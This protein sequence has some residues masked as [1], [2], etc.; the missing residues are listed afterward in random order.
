MRTY[1]FKLYNSDKNRYLSKQINVAA[2]VWNHTVALQRRYYRMYGKYAS[3]AKIQK[4]YTQLKKT[5][6]YS[7]W[8]QLG[9]QALQEVVQRV[10]RSYQA[11]FDYKRGKTQLKKSPP[12]FKKHEKYSSFTLKQAGYKLDEQ[13]GII[14]I[15]R[16]R[17]RYFK[18]RNIYGT[19][20]T[21]TVKRTPLGEYFVT[22][23]C[24]DSE[25]YPIPRAGKAVGMDF[26][27]K[28]FLTLSDG[29]TIDSPE[30]FKH[31]I[32][33]IRKANKRLSRCKEGSNHKRAAKKDLERAHEAIADRRKDWFYKLADRLTKEYAII[34]IEDLNI[35][36]MQKLWGRKISDYAFA[37]F[38]SILEWEALKNGCSV[39]K[40]DRWLPSS[41]A[42]HVCGA[43]NAN[44]SLKDRSW[45]CECCGTEHDRDINAAI[46]ILSAGL[47]A[48]A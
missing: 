22:I 14:E 29:S 45:R 40:V 28:H 42:C 36:A 24:D 48:T 12:K 37:E 7:F 27:L 33:E 4:H 43:I 10:D 35:K 6:R 25:T 5:R 13:N 1:K 47:A 16:R 21:L 46:N 31:S 26:G 41:K 17:Y 30:M 39:I 34:C 32:N 44:L 38:V 20:K 9:S 19:I 15:N 3:V 23:V 11:F 18:S 8:N 2:S